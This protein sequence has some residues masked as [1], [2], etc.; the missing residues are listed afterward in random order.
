MIFSEKLI[1][2]RK[3]NGWSQEELAEKM[4]VSRQAVS[5]WEGGQSVPDLE[6]LLQLSSLFGVTTDYLLKDEIE[7][8]EPCDQ[9]GDTGL[10]RI[11]LADANAFLAQRKRASRRIALATLLCILSPIPL[12]ILGA[13]TEIPSL[14]VS[15][16]VM[17]VIGLAALFAFVLCAIPLYIYSGFQNEPYRFLD[18]DQPFE[19]EYGVRG[20]VSE[21]QKQF[22]GAY[23]RWNITATCICVFSPIPLLLS[24]FS[25][26]A[27]VCVIMLSLT[28]LIAGIGVYCFIWVGVQNAAM[29]KLLKEG[30][31]TERE[32][33]RSGW[34]ESVG[35]AYWGILTAVYLAWS[36]LSNQWHV[37]WLVFAIGG[38][39]FPV[40]MRL[41]DLLADRNDRDKR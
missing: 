31:Y 39:L 16:T 37:T 19:L 14:G 1:R 8:E 29:Q 12:L 7:D 28:I 25:Q 13:A 2:L 38:V 18:Q 17:G 4:N 23:V 24:A 9:V 40:I 34:R 32:K 11:S 26:N 22:R 21:R 6:K 3:K 35:F 20:L 41:C 27:L 15:E 10:R 36:F 33:N 5:K 30:D